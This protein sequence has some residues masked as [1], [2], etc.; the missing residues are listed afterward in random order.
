MN[1]ISIEQLLVWAY[2]DQLVHVARGELVPA[3]LTWDYSPGLGGGSGLRYEMID[4]GARCDFAAHHDA[5]R[6]HEAVQALGP[7]SI[8][9][10]PEVAR[11]RRGNAL[12]GEIE[13]SCSERVDRRRLVFLHAVD[14]TQPDWIRTPAFRL[15]P[16]ELVYHPRNKRPWYCKVYPD[17]IS[18]A[19][20]DR[21]RAIWQAWIDALRDV[22]QAV[23]GD[24]VSHVLSGEFPQAEPWRPPVAAHAA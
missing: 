14:G 21:A 3:S 17:G 7:V 6:V 5:Y 18:A 16:G 12:A 23:R 9:V 15:K 20:V 1:K 2:R 4:A 8:A 10:A 22:A 13:A 11:A 19:E 24:L